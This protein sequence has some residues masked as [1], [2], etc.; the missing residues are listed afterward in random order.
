[1]YSSFFTLKIDRTGHNNHLF[2]Y[3]LF[4]RSCQQD[5]CFSYVIK[6]SQVEKLADIQ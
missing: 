6:I 3:E 2:E 1:M 4:Y 5:N